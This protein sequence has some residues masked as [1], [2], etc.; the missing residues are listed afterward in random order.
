MLKIDQT[1]ND[2][3]ADTL[4]HL[5][6]HDNWYSWMWFEVMTQDSGKHSCKHS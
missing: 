1:L 5:K 2:L 4:V 3:A 6:Q